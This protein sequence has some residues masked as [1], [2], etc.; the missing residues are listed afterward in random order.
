M[1]IMTMKAMTMMRALSIDNDSV[2]C[3]SSLMQSNK[4]FFYLRDN[5]K[6]PFGTV[7]LIQDGSL[8][9]I[10]VSLCRPGDPWSKHMGQNIAFGRAQENPIVLNSSD[11]PS[12]AHVLQMAKSSKNR[13][14]DGVPPYRMNEIQEVS[15]KTFSV[16]LE[17]IRGS[18][19][20]LDN[21]YNF[22]KK[23]AG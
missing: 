22:V 2:F 5:E 20:S 4:T 3:Y 9:K 14:K 12:L 10:G 17:K 8:T 19:N 16:A 18:K 7:A 13:Y 11:S 23:S 21:V 15:E 1:T 6:R